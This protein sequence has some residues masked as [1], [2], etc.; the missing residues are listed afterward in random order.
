MGVRSQHFDRRGLRYLCQSGAFTSTNLQ[1]LH[2]FVASHSSKQHLNKV[3]AAKF[4]QCM[5]NLTDF[6]F[7]DETR[8]IILR[9]DRLFM[10]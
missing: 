1:R 9:Q 7:M 2:I 4:L 3:E 6:S 10:S 8:K 5:P